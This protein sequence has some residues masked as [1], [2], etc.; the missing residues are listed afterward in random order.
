MSRN[1]SFNSLINKLSTL[2]KKSAETTSS[3]LKENKQLREEVN[4]LRKFK[5]NVLD[6]LQ[7]ATDPTT[8]ST[9]IPTTTTTTTTTSTTPTIPVVKE[10]SA[11]RQEVGSDSEND[12]DYVPSHEASSESSSESE[13]DEEKEVD[14]QPTRTTLQTVRERALNIGLISER[15][16][17][18]SRNRRLLIKAG[19]VISK[20]FKRNLNSTPATKPEYF[21][22]ADKTF[23]VK[24]YPSNMWSKVDEHLK[25]VFAE[26]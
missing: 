24:A 6:L 9:T 8:R 1:T 5:N 15:T 11:L 18:S 20:D 14:I 25:N 26:A 22:Y 7:F 13:W 10:E 16:K 3:L 19:Q 4:K 21:K 12:P 17:E 2:H 23:N